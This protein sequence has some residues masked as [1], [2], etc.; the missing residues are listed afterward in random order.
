MDEIEQR[1]LHLIFIGEDGTF[2]LTGDSAVR[3]QFSVKVK[4]CSLLVEAS[5]T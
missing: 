2:S 5:D 3:G 1:Q 4:Q